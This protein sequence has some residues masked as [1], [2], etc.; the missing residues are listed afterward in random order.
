[1]CVHH[2]IFSIRSPRTHGGFPFYYMIPTK[3][4]GNKTVPYLFRVVR[5]ER[6]NKVANDY[7]SAGWIVLKNGWPDLF[8]YNKKSG[9]IK[10]IEVKALSKFKR[11]N[12]KNRKLGLS[13]DQLRMH[14]Y[15]RKAGFTVEVVFV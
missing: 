5:N 3:I 2:G 7:Y 9:E 8:C 4:R 10:L 15:L 6:E 13:R 14:Q 1:M 12:K 11:R